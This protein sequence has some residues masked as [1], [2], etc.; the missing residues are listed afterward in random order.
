MA[1]SSILAEISASAGGTIC[2]PSPKID[3]VAV[4]LRRIVRCG[5]HHA[6]DAAKMADAEGHDRRRQRSRRDHGLEAGA[7]HDL[8]SVACED[9]GVAPGIETDDHLA[10]G[11]AMIK[12]VASQCGRCL[13]RRRL[14]SSDW[15]RD[16]AH[17]VTR[18]CRT[19]VA[20]R[21]RRRARPM[22]GR[23]PRSLPSEDHRPA[24]A[25]AGSGSC[26]VQLAMVRA[27]SSDTL[28]ALDVTVLPRF[29][30]AA[31]AVAARPPVRLPARP[32]G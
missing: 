14:G 6:G 31:A 9:V 23:L 26:A 5:H 13:S 11:Q 17:R 3:L 28:D 8:R 2:E 27:R 1:T 16:P 32:R 18:R 20:R 21:T 15:A 7:R 22:R 10:A 25:S 24:A 12:K 19:R 4:V 29:P 30:R